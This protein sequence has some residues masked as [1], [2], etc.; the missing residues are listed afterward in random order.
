M[1]LLFSMGLASSQRAKAGSGGGYEWQLGHQWTFTYDHATRSAELWV[2]IGS[3]RWRLREFRTEAEYTYPVTCSAGSKA[4][5]CLLDVYSAIEESY[6]R[7][8]YKDGQ[9]NIGSVEFYDD[10]VVEATG[11][12]SSSTDHKA[13]L[14]QHPS[15][16]FGTLQSGV[17][18]QFLTEW[19]S[20]SL[21]GDW[22]APFKAV[23]GTELTMRNRVIWEHEEHPNDYSKSLYEVSIDG[24][25]PDALGSITLPDLPGKKFAFQ[26][27]PTKLTI[28]PPA[29]LDLK[30][31]IVDPKF[32]S[33]GS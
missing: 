29:N 7:T 30:T 1:A 16:Q 28:T 15:M 6:Q 19:T 2:A 3:W 8:G 20:P 5:T 12:W 33:G 21:T 22:S 31:F 27:A 18:T 17:S 25:H 26:L 10:I 32:G 11:T 14:A 24:S 13:L 9:Y 23:P 4:T